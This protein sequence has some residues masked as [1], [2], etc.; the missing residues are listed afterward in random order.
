LT[1]KFKVK[2]ENEVYEVEV[3]EITNYNKDQSEIVVRKEKNRTLSTSASSNSATISN[4]QIHDTARDTIS[5]GEEKIIAPLPGTVVDIRVE[6]GEEVQKG[7]VVIVIETMKME[8]EITSPFSGIVREVL[9]KNGE[10][11]PSGQP[12]IVLY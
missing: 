2:I 3:E 8:N 9:V 11:V 12:L 10:T 7:E 5:S 1:R 4:S 6:P